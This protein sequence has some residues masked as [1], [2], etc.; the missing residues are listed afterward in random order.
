[1]R[2]IL[3][4]LKK[5]AWSGVVK[6]RNCHEDLAPYFTRSGRI[7]TGLIK[8]DEDRL[9]KVLGFDL[10]PGS[11]LWSNFFIR[12]GATD[13]YLDLNDPMD[14]LRYLF[15]KNH[16]RVKTSLLETKASANFVLLNKDEEA[17]RSNLYNR[18]KRDA[19]KEFDRLSAEDIRKVLRLFGHSAES[20]SNEVAESRLFEIV[21]GNPQM[22]LD[23]WVNNK[24]RETEVLIEKAISKNVVRKNKNVYRYGTD[25]IGHSRQDAIDFM[26]NPKNQ[27]LRIAIMQ[28][29]ESKGSIAS[30]PV[31][32]PLSDPEI[33]PGAEVDL[34]EAEVKSFVE[35]S[36]EDVAKQIVSEPLSEEEKSESKKTGRPKKGDTI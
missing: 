6:Y 33:V 19:M 9:S 12:T 5:N 11:E 22:F 30:E 17:K 29:I 18:V 35:K 14:E 21:E 36:S 8:A 31:N 15:L 32:E 3:R 24:S 23:K 13:L 10:S 1:M 28:Q 4:P 34:P 25:I 26:E 7:Y 27:D 20:L 2:V 16:K